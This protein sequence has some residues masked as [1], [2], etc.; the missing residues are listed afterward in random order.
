MIYRFGSFTLDGDTRQLFG[1]AEEVHL[2]PKAFELLKELLANR[3]RA[4]SKSELQK[5]IW[6]STFVEETNLATLVAEIR[7]ALREST[8]DSAFLRTVYGFGYQFAGEVVAGRSAASN[9]QRPVRLWL[10]FEPRQVPLMDGINVIGRAP[11][12]AIQIDSPGISRYHARIVVADDDATLEDMN[13]KNGTQLNGARIT[14]PSRIVDGDKIR[15]GAVVL[16][17][18]SQPRISPTASMAAQNV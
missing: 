1:G 9:E 2:T 6:P 14:G 7:R 11:D 16:I 13:S 12:A 10:I 17:V 5:R 18:R 4:V 8:A 3:G 15:L